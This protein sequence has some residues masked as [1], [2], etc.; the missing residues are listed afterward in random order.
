[1]KNKTPCENC[2]IY[3]L[4]FEN[5]SCTIF[6]RVFRVIKFT[7]IEIGCRPQN[8][9]LFLHFYV[10]VKD[11]RVIVSVVVVVFP[12]TTLSLWLAWLIVSC[13]SST[14]LG[15]I[16]LIRKKFF[17]LSQNVREPKSRRMYM[18]QH[19]V[20]AAAAASVHADRKI[21]WS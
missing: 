16:F 19:F 2:A 9:S 5:P 3:F 10:R 13:N 18:V 6:G 1:M 8:L 7:Q 14:Q 4:L 15:Y 12:T 17:L 21:S 20:V 11:G